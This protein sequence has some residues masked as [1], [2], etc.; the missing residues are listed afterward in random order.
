[1]RNQVTDT[2]KRERE[3]GKAKGNRGEKTIQVEGNGCRWI[4]DG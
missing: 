4:L 2:A 3:R 1:M